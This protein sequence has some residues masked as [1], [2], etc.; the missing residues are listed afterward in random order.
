MMKLPDY[1]FRPEFW[2]FQTP[3]K[4]WNFLAYL[5]MGFVCKMMIEKCF[6]MIWPWWILTTVLLINVVTLML[7][8]RPSYHSKRSY[9]TI[10]PLEGFES[11]LDCQGHN[12]FRFLAWFWIKLWIESF[13]LSWEKLM[14]EQYLIYFTMVTNNPS[15]EKFPS[16]ETTDSRGII[17]II[18]V[19]ANRH[20]KA[21]IEIITRR[22]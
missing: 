10:D 21:L 5:E 1:E 2:K 16:I 7:L 13:S 12:D 20:W 19:Y 18:Y 17:E 14:R 4:N 3:F 22:K 11:S 6:T 15:F 8:K 9:I